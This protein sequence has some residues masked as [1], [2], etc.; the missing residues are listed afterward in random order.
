M[1]SRQFSF[2]VVRPYSQATLTSFSR[3]EVE[4]SQD[5]SSRRDKEKGM[6][7]SVKKKTES[8]WCG[9]TKIDAPGWLRSHRI[10]MKRQIKSYDTNASMART[11][12]WQET[13]AKCGQY[14]HKATIGRANKWNPRTCISFI[15]LYVRN[16]TTTNKAELGQLFKHTCRKWNVK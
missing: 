15:P 11:C 10:S 2:S 7:K 12:C 4:A 5:F 6:Y 14:S 13:T 1:T 8:R 9:P 16:P 3:I